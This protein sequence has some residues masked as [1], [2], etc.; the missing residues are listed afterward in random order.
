MADIGNSPFANL[1]ALERIASEALQEGRSKGLHDTSEIARAI[2]TNQRLGMQK[3]GVI[4]GGYNGS[5]ISF[6]T[7][8]PRDPMFYWREANL[9]FEYTKDDEIVR[10]RQYANLVYLTDPVIAACIDVYAYW[11]LTGMHIEHEDPA[12]QKFYEELFLDDNTGMNY[13]EFLPQVLHETFLT[14][15]SF[16]FGHFNELLGIWDYDELIKADDVKVI[17]SP[18]QRDPRFEIKV[19][20]DIRRIISEREPIWEYQR[21]VSAYPSLMRYAQTEEYMPVSSALLQQVAVKP[22]K[23]HSRGL[24][25]MMRAFRS[26]YQQEMLNAAMDSI[27]SRLYTPLILVRLGASAQDTGTDVAWVPTPQDLEQFQE[28]LDIALAADFRVLTSHFATQVDMVFGREAMPDFGPDFDRLMDNKLLAFGLSRTM[29]AGASSGETY[30]ADAINRDLVTMMLTRAQRWAK[31]LFAQ[32]V[33]LVAEA[34][35]HFEVEKNGSERSVVMQEV[36]VTDEQTGERRILRKPKLMQPKLLFDVLNLR[37]EAVE[38]Q[39]VE[40]LVAMGVPISARTRMRG[41]NIDLDVELEKVKQE[42]VDRAVAAEETRKQTY[43]ELRNQRLAVP[44]DL[45][46]D[47]APKP[48]QA[49]APSSNTGSPLPTPL[50]PV[51]PEDVLA[52]ATEEEMA[53]NPPAP[54]APPGTPPM[55]VGGPMP[56]QVPPEGATRP[57]ESDEQRVGMPRPASAPGAVHEGGV[58][59]GWHFDGDVEHYLTDWPSQ[60]IVPVIK[61]AQDRKVDL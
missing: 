30:A 36:M 44:E 55:A 39:F 57:P 53:K 8:R 46:A 22:D 61:M 49:P 10:L 7:A 6:A 16:P 9:P 15:E 4:G 18:F 28:S 27:A 54:S 42:Q 19:P 13:T 40:N 25:I 3:T 26:L 32:R 52:P 14:G 35:E 38:R 11:P 58:K 47:Y 1:G 51:V 59:L 60:W 50:A 56:V 43:Q 21:L 24:P 37:D 17:S 45:D 48:L 33:R 29:L 12:I 2:R 20:E 34:Q 31:R 41:L 5:G 23:F